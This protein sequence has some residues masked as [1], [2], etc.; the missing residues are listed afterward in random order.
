MKD[1]KDCEY[2][3]GYDYSDGTPC[4]ENDG[5]YECCPFNDM[6]NV[7]KNGI[8]IEIDAG[9]MH[10]YILHTMKNT[11]EGQAYQVASSEIKSLI[12]D[13]MKE[14]VFGEIKSQVGSFVSDAISDFMSKEIVVGN[15][16]SEPERSLTRTQYL[17]ETIEKELKE[18]FKGDAIKSYAVKEVKNAIDTYERKLRDEINAEIKNHFDTATRQILTE[19]VV[20]MLMS[21]DTY[22]KLSNSM[23]TFLPSERNGG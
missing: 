18:K 23:Q 8:K 17:A 19:N 10:D 11:I 5:G 22:Q 9:F 3:D 7:K 4:C 6:S 13:E 1:C 21:N 2:F 14:I 12:T 15:G 20:S 16:W